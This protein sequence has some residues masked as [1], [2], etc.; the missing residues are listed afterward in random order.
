MADC[1]MALQRLMVNSLEASLSGV[2]GED[3]TKGSSFAKAADPWST[4]DKVGFGASVASVA[5]SWTVGVL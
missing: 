1:W 3:P 4:R 2:K 5:F